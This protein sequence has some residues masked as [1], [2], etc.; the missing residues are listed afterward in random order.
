M[1]GKRLR[2]RPRG[3]HRSP[4]DRARCAAMSRSVRGVNGAELDGAGLVSSNIR[5]GERF[6]AS[7]AYL[8]PAMDRPNLDVRTEAQGTREGAV[9]D[10]LLRVHGVTGLRV[11]GTP[12]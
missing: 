6:S 10:A 8:H 1:R 3:A 7:R 2:I 5:D 9:V 4:R 12:R 11:A